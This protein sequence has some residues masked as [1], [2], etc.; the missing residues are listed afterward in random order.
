M[1]EQKRPKP[2]PYRLHIGLR[3]TQKILWT[4][5]TDLNDEPKLH[6]RTVAGAL[7][8]LA[9]DDY[10]SVQY[11]AGDYTG[12]ITIEHDP[13]PQ[14]GMIYFVDH[15]F[16]IAEE[17]DHGKDSGTTAQLWSQWHDRKN[18]NLRLLEGCEIRPPTRDPSEPEHERAATDAGGLQKS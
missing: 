1:T 5:L 2:A 18:A 16:R 10:T 13:I 12:T 6:F 14:S 17:P 8:M 3:I 7:R 11:R 9:N 15:R 4:M